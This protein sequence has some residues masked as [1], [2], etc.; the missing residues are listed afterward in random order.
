MKN[1]VLTYLGLI[2][3]SFKYRAIKG[4]VINVIQFERKGNNLVT[5]LVENMQQILFS[6]IDTEFQSFSNYEKCG[7][8]ISWAN[9]K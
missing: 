7:H 5:I 3:S 4:L 8:D 6:V 2:L 9:I 1:V